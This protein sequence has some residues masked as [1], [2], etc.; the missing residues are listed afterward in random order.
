MAAIPVTF[1]GY[2]TYSDLSIGGGP[3]V[4]G[5]GKPPGIWGGPPAYVDIGPPQPQP[6]PGWPPVIMPPIYYPPTPPQRPPGIWGGPPAYVD[7]GP[8]GPQPVPGW[9]P[10]IMPPIYLPPDPPGTKPPDGPGDGLRPEHP[11][12]IPPEPSP[13]NPGGTRALVIVPGVGSVWFYIQPP[14]KP[15]EPPTTPTPKPKP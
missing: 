9:P 15:V 5:P 7:I 13:P 6:I 11:I 2:M 4:G 1:V 3:I 14:A 12:V 8:P 10:V